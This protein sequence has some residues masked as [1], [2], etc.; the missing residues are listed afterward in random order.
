M[1]ARMSPSR[2]RATRS[3]SGNDAIVRYVGRS[4]KGF[5]RVWWPTSMPKGRFAICGTRGAPDATA[6]SVSSRSR[7]HGV[8]VGSFSKRRKLTGRCVSAASR[9]IHPSSPSA[10][11]GASPAVRP[12][13]PACATS[14]M[15]RP[16]AAS[17]R[18]IANS[19]SSPANVP[20]HRFPVDR[21]V[22]VRARG[23]EPERARLDS[24]AHE[25]RHRGDVLGGRGFVA[26]P[27]ITHD[28]G[29]QR[30]VR[31]VRADVDQARS[32]RERVEVLRKALPVPRQIP[33]PSDSPGMSSTP[34]MRPISQSWRSGRAGAKP[35]PQ[36]P[37]TSVV[38]P[39]QLDGARIGSQ[40]AWPS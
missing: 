11:F 26:R 19:S 29:A 4:A 30:A 2:R 22:P 40:S 15:P 8:A 18:P 33:P 27:A 17:A 6:A 36:L 10:A 14:K 23:R 39:C 7:R 21:A 20:G 31:D 28:V 24:L 32:A 1:R 13:V 3:S 9:R 12:P 5:A 16:A 35:T 34:C 38:T 25:A 37:T